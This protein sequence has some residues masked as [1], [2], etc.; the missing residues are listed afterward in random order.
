MHEVK[1]DGY[2]VIAR[3]DGDR[4]PKFSELLEL[5]LTTVEPSLAG[6]KR[7]QDRAALPRV[8]ESFTA[9]LGNGHW[10]PN[11]SPPSFAI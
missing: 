5:D 10:A 7:P 1:W 3:K 6:P 4:V 2:R 9:A 11:V 8:W